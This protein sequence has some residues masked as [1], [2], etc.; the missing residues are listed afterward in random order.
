MM[1]KIKRL[2]LNLLLITLFF[3]GLVLIF[4]F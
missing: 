4:N 3:T 2:S 1:K